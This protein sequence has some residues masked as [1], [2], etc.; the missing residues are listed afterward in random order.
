MASYTLTN[1]FSNSSFENTGW[2]ANSACTVAYNTSIKRS[3]SYSLQVTSTSTSESLIVNS[4]TMAL[5]QNH[6][7]YCSAYIYET[8]NVCSMLQAYWPIA[9]PYW[10]DSKL[11]TTK[12][13]Q[14]QKV[15]WR[16]V[17]SNWNSGN[18]QFRFD[19]EGMAA[20]TIIYIDDALLI[21]LTAIFGS[22]NEP[23]K[24]VV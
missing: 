8:S 18:Y 1:M 3:G 6:I 21:D 10:G 24:R 5:T 2:T 13:N 9:E 15:S 22:G 20:N 14:W 4:T 17:R 23:P 12:L 7:Y 19:F 16:A 11:D